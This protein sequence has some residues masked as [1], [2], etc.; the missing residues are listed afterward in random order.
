MPKTV[1]IIVNWNGWRDTVECLSSVYKYAGTGCEAVVVDNGSQDGSVGKIAQW[2]SE[3]AEDATFLPA[4]LK[5]IPLVRYDRPAAEQGGV[6]A[7]RSPL[8]IIETGENLGFAGGNNVGIRYALSRR[9]DY[10]LLLNNDAALLNRDSLASL[11]AFM[12]GMPKAG[13][14]GGRLFYQ[15][16]TA[17]Q[18]YGNF[19]SIARTL[20]YLFPLQRIIPVSFR[21]SFRSNVVPDPLVQEPFPI[22]YPS[23]AFFLV[24]ARTIRELGMLD[25]RYFMYVEETDWCFRMKQAGW[26]RYCV[27]RATAMHKV[28]GSFRKG[29]SRMHIYFMESLIRYFGKHFSRREQQTVIAAFLLRSS[30]AAIG[31]RIACFLLPKGQADSA[32]KRLDHWVLVR[33]KSAEAMRGFRGHQNPCKE[34]AIRP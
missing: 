24:R 12:E 26:D 22:D 3:Y 6:K 33:R 29:P 19:P 34:A 27:P 13:A 21:K 30:L 16:G 11:L 25:E 17:Q 18:S 2:A 20:G 23:G 15:N 7:D 1:I 5:G 32:Q 14:C 31:W 28:A 4:L 8:V 9:A 10:I